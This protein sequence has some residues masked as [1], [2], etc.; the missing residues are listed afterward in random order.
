MNVSLS[1]ALGAEPPYPLLSIQG[2]GVFADASKAGVEGS[3]AQR[4]SMPSRSYAR[5]VKRWGDDRMTWQVHLEF[6]S[7]A[8][9][10]RAMLDFT[11]RHRGKKAT[12]LS[13]LTV[14]VGDD[15]EVEDFSRA[16]CRVVRI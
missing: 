16:A 4:Y 6:G 7:R 5:D 11:D 14:R 15:G 1:R 2:K 13:A 12:W 8:D 3:E 9:A 10:E